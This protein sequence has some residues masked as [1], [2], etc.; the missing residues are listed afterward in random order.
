MQQARAIVGPMITHS[1]FRSNELNIRVGSKSLWSQHTVNPDSRW[2]GA[3]DFHCLNRV[4]Q[5]EIEEDFMKLA[6]SGLKFRQLIYEFG[7]IHIGA[8]KGWADDG[9]VFIYNPQRNNGQKIWLKRGYKDVTN[10]A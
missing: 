4:T 5:K 6:N 10:P 3:C 7:W 1:V 9:Q 8:P 2:W